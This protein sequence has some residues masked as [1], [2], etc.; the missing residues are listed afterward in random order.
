MIFSFLEKA[1]G[2]ITNTVNLQLAY[3]RE[4][5]GVNRGTNQRLYVVPLK[6]SPWTSPLAVKLAVSF[7]NFT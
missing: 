4:G 5:G 7:L 1:Q 2:S 3:L 6:N